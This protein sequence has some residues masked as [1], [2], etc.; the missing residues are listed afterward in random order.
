MSD[1]AERIEAIELVASTKDNIDIEL[2][3]EK[4]STRLIRFDKKAEN[5]ITDQVLPKN[6]ND[7]FVKGK[8]YN[9]QYCTID[10]GVIN[11]VEF[12]SEYLEQVRHE[13]LSAHLFN[14]PLKL[15][16]KSTFVE[17]EPRPSDAV[18]ICFFLGE[19]IVVK[20]VTRLNVRRIYFKNGSKEEIEIPKSGR[21]VKDVILE[22]SDGKISFEGELFHEDKINY[23]IEIKQIDPEPFLRLSEFITVRY[24][25]IMGFTSIISAKTELKRPSILSKQIK[26]TQETKGRIFIVNDQVMVTDLLSRI[27]TAHGYQCFAY[28]DGREIVELANRQK[29]DAVIL[30]ISLPYYDGLTILRRLK[31]NRKTAEIPVIMFTGSREEDDVID[32]MNAGAAHYIVKSADM[33]LGD[34]VAKVDGIVMAKK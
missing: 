20:K 4:Y 12:A 7:L 27:L 25:E 34:I 29:P 30:D 3:G 23:R 17:V 13:G 31:R 22:L 6:G 26:R 21:K 19:L 28:N 1:K 2:E 24:C 16:R 5:F 11:L 10:M 14:L 9:F 18:T 8:N 15:Q 33:D 32:A